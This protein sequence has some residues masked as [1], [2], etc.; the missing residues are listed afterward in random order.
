MGSLTYEKDGIEIWK[1]PKQN[2]ING[3]IGIFNR[4][5]EIK[6]ISLKPEDL[7]FDSAEN[8]NLQNVWN[9]AEASN[10]DFIINPNGVAFLKYIKR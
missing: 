6:S 8:Y 5:E 9:P 7:G 4:T 10:F 3:W 2:S 1:T